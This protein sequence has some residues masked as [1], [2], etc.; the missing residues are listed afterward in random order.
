MVVC[1]DVEFLIGLLEEYG[2]LG[3]FFYDIGL[4]WDMDGSLINVVGNDF[5]LC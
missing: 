2:I 4:F 3:G 1:F 5:F